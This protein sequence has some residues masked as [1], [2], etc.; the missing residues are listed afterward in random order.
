MGVNI[1]LIIFH[2]YR[3][4]PG[5]SVHST[6][7]CQCQRAEHSFTTAHLFYQGFISTGCSDRLWEVCV[8]KGF[9]RASLHSVHT[10]NTL[11]VR[12]RI[13]NSFWLQLLFIANNG[14]GCAGTYAC[15]SAGCVYT[16]V[17]RFSARSS[18]M[19]LRGRCYDVHSLI[20]LIWRPSGAKS[21]SCTHTY[22]HSVLT[23]SDIFYRA[24]T[25]PT[26]FNIIWIFST[27][28]EWYQQQR[29]H[30]RQRQLRFCY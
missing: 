10:K 22:I 12:G 24:F 25:Q 28:F 29:C 23:H 9:I 16:C 15:E 4:S 20:P 27:V 3:V 14:G 5:L 7:Q 6:V 11:R 30:D 21:M 2:S 18:H 1:D 26:A 13:I 8:Y 19:P 17:C